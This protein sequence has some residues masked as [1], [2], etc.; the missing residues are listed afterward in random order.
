MTLQANNMS[1]PILITLK[2]TVPGSSGDDQVDSILKK[3]KSIR[4]SVTILRDDNIDFERIRDQYIIHLQQCQ[5]D[6]NI[7]RSIYKKLK[8]KFD[9]GTTEEEQ[10]Q[11]QA[12][13]MS[14][15]APTTPAMRKISTLE[16]IKITPLIEVNQNCYTESSVRLKFAL[17]TSSVICTSQYSHDGNKIAFADGNYV[18][19]IQ[20]DDGEILT[21]IALNPSPSTENA[22]TRVLRFSP[23]DKLIAL[24]S[25]NDVLLFDANTTKLLHRFEGHTKEVSSIAFNKDGTWLLTG[26]FDGLLLIWDTH[27]YAQIKNLSHSNNNNSGTDGAIVKIATTPEVPFYSIGFMNGIIGIYDEFFEQ[28]MMSFTAHSKILMGIAVSA[29]DDTI[30]TV[31]QD[32]T[33]KVWTMRG[34]AMCRHTLSGHTNMVIAVTFSPKSPIMFTGS[35]DQT[36][37]MWNQKTGV[38]LAVINAHQDTVFEIDHHPTNNQFVS[39]SGEGVVCVWDY[40]NPK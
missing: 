10:Q 30:G 12:P 7:L 40:D 4:Q 6:H 32:Q 23:D 8:L 20:S 33:V 36:V 9:L 35:K 22:H 29:L 17:N 3:V 5:E 38:N 25:M 28:P 39:C 19:I 37:R 21:T 14:E 27:S 34:I 13:M 1:N 24:G 2:S 16:N 18:Y 31:S 15:V 11:T 26:G